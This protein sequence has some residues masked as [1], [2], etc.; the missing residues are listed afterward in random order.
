MFLKSEQ[1]R[2][3]IERESRGPFDGGCTSMVYSGSQYRLL[4]T[5]NH[6]QH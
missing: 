2:A 6:G 3:E 5:R 1:G 4:L